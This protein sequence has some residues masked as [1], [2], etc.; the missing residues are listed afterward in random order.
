[1]EEF[2]FELVPEVVESASLDFGDEMMVDPDKMER[3]L[4]ICDGADELYNQLECEEFS[5]EVDKEHFG[6]IIK[7]TCEYMELQT[8]EDSAYYTALF[9]LLDS[10][11]FYQEK[12]DKLSIELS[13]KGL[14]VKKDE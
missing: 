7:L 14:W 2:I 9:P 8:R 10:I 3:L 13:I 11:R 4:E 5:V 6:I 1:M 12:K